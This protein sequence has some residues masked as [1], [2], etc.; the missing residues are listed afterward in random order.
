MQ[1]VLVHSENCPTSSARD[2][3]SLID[4]QMITDADLNE[5]SARTSAARSSAEHV[6]TGVPIPKPT[7]VAIFSPNEWESFTQEWATSLNN[8]YCRVARFGSGDLGI[9]VVGFVTDATFHGGWD[10]YQCK[11][12]DHPLHPSDIWVEIGKIIYYS[13]KGEYPPPRK[14]YFVA[15]RDIG[16]SLEKLLDCG[17]HAGLLFVATRLHFTSCG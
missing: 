7:R 10:N 17:L 6:S 3:T 1:L 13:Y 12:Y 9:D 11:R 5:I 15:S 14:H 8:T 4:V 16:T 2:I